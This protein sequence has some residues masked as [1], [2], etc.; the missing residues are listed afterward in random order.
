MQYLFAFS[1]L[2]LMARPADII[3]TKNT[4]PPDDEQKMA[5]LILEEIGKDR[6]GS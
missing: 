2:Q 4:V 3:L 5:Q 1:L 6:L